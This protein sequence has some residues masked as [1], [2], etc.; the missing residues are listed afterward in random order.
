MKTTTYK[1]YVIDTDNL[2]RVYIYNQKSPYS[3]DADKK[4]LGHPDKFTLKVVKAYID[5]L[6]EN[7]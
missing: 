4:I 2:G 1:G 3:E 5:N 6:E 7:I